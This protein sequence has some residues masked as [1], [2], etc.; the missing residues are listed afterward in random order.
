[1]YYCA[2]A[3]VSTSVN[4][5]G[6]AASLDEGRQWQRRG[7][8]RQIWRRRSRLP[9]AR[10]VRVRLW[11]RQRALLPVTEHKSI[12]VIGKWQDSRTRD[13]CILLRVVL[14]TMVLERADG[15]SATDEEGWFTHISF[16]LSSAMTNVTKEMDAVLKLCAEMGVSHDT[17]IAQ[18]LMEYTERYQKKE[19]D[20]IQ[21][22]CRIP[23]PS[24]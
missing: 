7:G 9:A 17:I 16:V 22:N 15:I 13:G 18:G 5:A 14:P 23:L 6:S 19:G 4:L 1:M 24:K 3:L 8:R 21:T 10:C 2:A 12:Y 11:C 20:E